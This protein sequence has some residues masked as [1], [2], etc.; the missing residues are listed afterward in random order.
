MNFW[1][2]RIFEGP[3]SPIKRSPR[4]TRRQ[5][6]LE[7]RSKKQ[8]TRLSEL[9]NFVFRY[10]WIATSFGPEKWQKPVF[11]LDLGTDRIWKSRKYVRN[12]ATFNL[13]LNSGLN[14]LPFHYHTTAIWEGLSLLE[15]IFS[16]KWLYRESSND[17]NFIVKVTRSA[18]SECAIISGV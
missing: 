7:R 11:D 15:N 13:S 5:I 1:S 6:E 17:I 10:F 12:D 4:A 9:S 3:K 14:S 16:R 8:S 2:F 18:K